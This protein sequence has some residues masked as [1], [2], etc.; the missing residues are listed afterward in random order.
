MADASAF[1]FSARCARSFSISSCSLRR[2]Y[3]FSSDFSRSSQILDILLPLE[4]PTNFSLS[5]IPI[6]VFLTRRQTESLPDT[7]YQIH[8][9]R[10]LRSLPRSIQAPQLRESCLPPFADKRW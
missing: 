2:K 5:K 6:I 4:C 9:H 7:Q 3:S 1:S 10:R 8:Y